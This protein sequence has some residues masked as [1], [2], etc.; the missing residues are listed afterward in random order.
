MHLEILSKSSVSEMLGLSL[1]VGNMILAFRQ[2]ETNNQQGGHFIELLGKCEE[3]G[4]TQAH[5]SV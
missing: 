2:F 4:S 5:F 3:I 1:K